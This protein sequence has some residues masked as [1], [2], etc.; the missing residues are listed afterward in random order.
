MEAPKK[1]L[2]AKSKQWPD[3]TRLTA[4]VGGVAGV[5]FQTDSIEVPNRPCFPAN[6][7]VCSILFNI[8]KLVL[9]L[10]PPRLLSIIHICIQS[11]H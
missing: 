3:T 9:I 7:L 4:V 11:A 2:P 8:N 6:L 10:H 1:V 5:A